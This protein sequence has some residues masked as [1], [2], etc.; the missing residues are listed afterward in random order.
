MPSLDVVICT[1]NRAADLDRCLDALARQDPAVEGDWRVTVIDNNCTDR[2]ADVVEAHV[3]RGRIPGLTRRIEPQQ[4]LTPARQAGVRG[5]DADWIGFVDDDCGVA[6]NWVAQAVRFAA[7]R[8]DAGAFG[9]RVRPD[10]CRTPPTHLARH[11]WLFAAQDHGDEVCRVESLVGAGVVVNRRALGEVGWTAEPFLADRTG[12]GHVSGGDVE[13][14]F[15]L[16]R[17]GHCLW[18]V[19]SLRIDHRIAPSRQRM[20]DLLRLAHGLGAGAELVSL[21]GSSDV[22][23]WPRQTGL[24]LRQELRRHFASTT[25]VLRGRYPWQDWMIRMAFLAGQR[26]QHRALSRD[27]ATRDRLGGVWAR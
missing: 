9:G 7:S 3:R 18:Y 22:G 15:R 21:M 6:S 8:P 13:I 25:Y 16:G 10:W 24:I 11:A 23:G 2:T 14:S 1:Y 19:P 26:A 17:A 27:E 4:G 12:L 20:P 5:S